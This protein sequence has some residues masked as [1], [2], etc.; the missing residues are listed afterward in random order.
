M[1]PVKEQFTEYD[2]VKCNNKRIK[3]KMLSKTAAIW[4]MVASPVTVK[5]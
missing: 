5:V 1:A 4:F 2:K 3:I